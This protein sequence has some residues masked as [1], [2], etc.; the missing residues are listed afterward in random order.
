MPIYVAKF[1]GQCVQ[2]IFAK[3]TAFLNMLTEQMCFRIFYG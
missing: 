2:I 1:S 3:T